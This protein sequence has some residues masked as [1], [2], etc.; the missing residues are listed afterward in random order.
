MGRIVPLNIFHPFWRDKKNREKHDFGI[1]FFIPLRG[2]KNGVRLDRI[3]AGPRLAAFPIV[4]YLETPG[5]GA[6]G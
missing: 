5:L 1:F 2:M 6:H 4:C 3:H